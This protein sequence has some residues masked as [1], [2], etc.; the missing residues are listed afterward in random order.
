[1]IFWFLI[2]IENEIVLEPGHVQSFRLQ[3]FRSENAF[4]ITERLIEVLVSDDVGV[5]PVAP[6]LFLHFV[7]SPL[8]LFL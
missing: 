1:M 7:K 4:E 2:I 3:T 5:F 6:H 8:N